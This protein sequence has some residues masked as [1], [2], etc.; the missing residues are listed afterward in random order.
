MRQFEPII[1]EVESLLSNQDMRLKIEEHLQKKGLVAKKDQD[2]N[3]IQP[4]E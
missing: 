1:N 2:P 3:K 4:V